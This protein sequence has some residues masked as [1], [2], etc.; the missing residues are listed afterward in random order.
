MT[1]CTFCGRA[2][3]PGAPRRVVYPL[4]PRLKCRNSESGVACLEC[5]GAVLTELLGLGLVR[6]VPPPGQWAHGV[7]SEV[8]T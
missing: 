2:I 7:E 1:A 8:L 4:P 3:E 6:P 5:F